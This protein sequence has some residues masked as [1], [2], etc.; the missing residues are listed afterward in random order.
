MIR[1]VLSINRQLFTVRLHFELVL[2][3]SFF[4]MNLVFVLKLHQENTTPK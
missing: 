2:T 3:G 4:I 1:S